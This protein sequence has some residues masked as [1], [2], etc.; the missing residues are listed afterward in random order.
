MYAFRIRSIFLQNYHLQGNF[1]TYVTKTRPNSS[2]LGRVG[3]TEYLFSLF[4]PKMKYFPTNFIDFVTYATILKKSKFFGYK[5]KQKKPAL[6][7]SILMA[8]WIF[9]FSICSPDCPKPPKV[10][11]FLYPIISNTISRG[12]CCLPYSR[13][14]N[15]QF[16]YFKTT[17][18]ILR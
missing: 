13:R 8:V 15:P 11:R 12:I 3:P 1:F 6:K 14:Y 9:F 16:V 10:Y 5:N 2:T 18:F 17:F 7:I 4:W